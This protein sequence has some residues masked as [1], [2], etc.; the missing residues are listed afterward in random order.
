MAERGKDFMLLKF[1][2]HW[3]RW[4]KAD[5]GNF[6]VGRMPAGNPFVASVE[7]YAQMDPGDVAAA[8][9]RGKVAVALR[10]K[11]ENGLWTGNLMPPL[12]PRDQPRAKPAEEAGAPWDAE[13][14]QPGGGDDEIPF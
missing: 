7:F 9:P 3:I 8:D 2:C 6:W 14:T 11:P 4:R 1:P 12:A 5:G 13:A 10:R